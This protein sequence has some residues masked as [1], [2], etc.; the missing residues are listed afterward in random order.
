MSGR[1][2]EDDFDDDGFVGGA[3]IDENGSIEGW[4]SSPVLRSDPAAPELPIMAPQPV[5]VARP[6]AF[7]AP[8]PLPRDRNVRLAMRMDCTE[9]EATAGNGALHFTEITKRLSVW[10]PCSMICGHQYDRNTYDRGGPFDLNVRLLIDFHCAEAEIDGG[11]GDMFYEF[12]R[13]LRRDY[14]AAVILCRRYDRGR[15]NAL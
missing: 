10:F 1:D 6:L 3:D 7:L 4:M 15:L 5:L 9:E 11:A 8:R 13:F 14:P 2:I 12:H